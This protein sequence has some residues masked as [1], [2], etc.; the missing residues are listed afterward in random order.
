[1]I[2]TKVLYS[3]VREDHRPSLGASSLKLRC[4]YDDGFVIMLKGCESLKV[5]VN[6]SL[7]KEKAACALRDRCGGVGCI[8]QSTRFCRGC[9]SP[10]APSVL[11]ESA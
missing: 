6:H 2:S 5:S 11:A 10:V 7:R 9:R 8:G 4:L 1:M 3:G